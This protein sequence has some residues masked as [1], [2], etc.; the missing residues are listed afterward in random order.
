MITVAV[1]GFLGLLTWAA[2]RGKPRADPETGT[3]V[4]RHSILF[5][6]FSLLAAF[7]IP[8]GITALVLVN[9]PKKDGD[10]TAIVCLYALFGALSAP[11]LWE[12]MRFSLTVSPEGLDCRSPWR[13]GRFVAWEEVQKLTYGGASQWF[14]IHTKDRWKFRVSIFVSGLNQF[15]EQFEKHLP[16]EALA[17]ARQGYQWVGRPFYGDVPKA[18]VDIH[19][20]IRRANQ[21]ED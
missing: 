21:S 10:V 7:G 8:L 18:P 3:L 16:Q 1:V 4:F 5:R 11:L 9:P 17:G 2:R 19:E 20:L 14:I 6:G 12:S 15:L 13:P